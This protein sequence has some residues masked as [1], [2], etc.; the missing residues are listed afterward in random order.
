MAQSFSP[1]SWLMHVDIIPMN[2]DERGRFAFVS[3][4]QVERGSLIVAPDQFYNLILWGSGFSQRKEQIL[5]YFQHLA[6]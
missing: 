1:R 6:G 4:A 2:A 3:A 5:V